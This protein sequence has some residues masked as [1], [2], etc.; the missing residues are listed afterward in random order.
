MFE[1]FILYTAIVAT[2]S[3]NMYSILILNGSNFKDFKDNIFIVLSCMDLDLA[4][5]MERPSTPTDSRSFIDKV[6]YEK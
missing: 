3:A 5:R 1:F 2:I 4:L 6:N